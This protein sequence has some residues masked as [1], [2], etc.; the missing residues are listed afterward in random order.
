M[1]LFDHLFIVSCPFYAGAG[2]GLASLP[3]YLVLEQH[4]QED[5]P[6]ALSLSATCNY[7]GIGVLPLFLQY[8]KNKYGTESGLILLGAILWHL[9]PCGLG[10][11]SPKSADGEQT[12]EESDEPIILCQAIDNI[13]MREKSFFQKYFFLFL[14]YVPSQEL[15][16]PHRG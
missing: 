13:N 5:F 8:L 2:F 16:N 9:I 14:L 6:T 1:A 12:S 15:Y 11:L 4:F 7:I 10:L 3:S